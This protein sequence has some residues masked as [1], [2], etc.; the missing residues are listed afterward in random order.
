M[1]SSSK[2]TILLAIWLFFF[3]SSIRTSLNSKILIFPGD[4]D[5]S[6]LTGTLVQEKKEE[7]SSWTWSMINFKKHSLPSGN[8]SSKERIKKWTELHKQASISACDLHYT[9]L[10]YQEALLQHKNCY[11]WSTG[12]Q[13][14][15]GLVKKRRFYKTVEYYGY[16]SAQ[17]K[18]DG[19][20]R[21]G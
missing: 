14:L 5:T 18:C 15:P 1:N 12:S 6:Y 10:Y 16:Q 9:S 2:F 21:D 11:F 3:K 8:G 20:V 13:A 4:W 17:N 19:T 7:W